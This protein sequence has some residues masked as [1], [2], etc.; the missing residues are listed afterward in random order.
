M[1]TGKKLTAK[2]D[3]QE[4]GADVDVPDRRDVNRREFLH[5][6]LLGAAGIPIAACAAGTTIPDRA[7][8]IST[9]DS[10]A[11]IPLDSPENWTE[12]WIWRPSDWPGQQLHL[13][14]V[15][16]EN[17]GAIV[18]FGNPSA[19]L[20]SYNGATPGPTIRME[21]NET[22]FVRLR[23]LLDEDIGTTFV[24]PFLDPAGGAI[25]DYFDADAAQKKASDQGQKRS[26]YC[27]GEHTNGVHSIHVTN[28]HT[29]GLHVRPGRNPDGTHSD[30]VILRLINQADFRRREQQSAVS[31][32]A[33]LGDPEQTT[34]LQ[35][36]EQPGFADYEFRIG[37]VQA[38]QIEKAGLPPQPH[39]PGTHWYHPHSH[40]AT[41]N[42]VA[43]GM[44]GFLIVEGDV[45]EA[46]NRALTDK[47][48]PNPQL[49][50]GTYDYMERLMFMQRVFTGNIAR[51]QDGPTQTLKQGGSANL[52][53][54][55]DQTPMIIKMR[56]GAIERWRILNGS[57]DGR[58][59]KRFMVLKGQYDVDESGGDELVHLVDPKSGR[60]EPVTRAQVEAD[61]QQLY[62]L[63]FDGVTLVEGGPDGAR[64][65]IKNLATQNHGTTNPL[66]GQ[67]DRRYP[68]RTM[69]ANFENCFRDATTINNCFVRPNEV[70]LGPANRTDVFFQA[71]RE[72]GRYTVLARAVVVHADNYQNTLMTPE[73]YNSKD[74]A[75][76][77]QDIVVAYII[78]EEGKDAQGHNLPP[79]PEYDV[80]KLIDVLPDVPPYLQ[81]IGDDEVRVK[82]GDSDLSE[83]RGKYRTRTITYSG[84]GSADFPLVTTVEGDSK[85]SQNPVTAQNF[86]KFV[87]ADQAHDALLRDL[88]YTQIKVEDGKD[89]D[90]KIRWKPVEPEE[91]VLLPANIRSMAIT[92]STSDELTREGVPKSRGRKFDPTDVE[93]PMML[94]GTAE[95]W[96]L[97]NYSISLWADTA[98]DNQ[99]V[100]Q[101]KGH[102]AA[103]P[104]TRAKGQANFKQQSNDKKSWQLVTKS[105]DHPFHIHQN[106]CWVTRIEIPDEKGNLVNILD[107]PRWQ[108]VM[109]I[110]RN[111]GRVIFRSRFPDYVGAYVNHCHILLHEDNGMMQVIEVTP[112]ANQANYEA[113]DQLAGSSASSE[114][115]SAI[116]PR[117]T[118]DEAWLQSMQFIDPNDRTGQEYPGFE[119]APPLQRE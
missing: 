21:G 74:L 90:G 27:L 87:E 45:D 114:D 102:Y 38:K 55:G 39:P 68:N 96:A 92:G 107:A 22:L 76:G 105:V 46:I 83:Q 73:T 112:F 101:Y 24:G 5:T 41:H 115:V 19:V 98:A 84:W 31:E 43:S 47:P 95:E 116:Y 4:G 66:D 61:K 1:I 113:K 52:A 60:F 35:D 8:R 106:P 80:M 33:F 78:V 93:R 44:A 49:K 9:T 26:D 7:K 72:P 15:E 14:V 97:Y 119:I 108:D 64:Y 6:A 71:P 34:F 91:Y 20:F 117:K 53:V 67:L 3:N 12:P 118:L 62:Q 17:P 54:N 29:H 70:Y 37:N 88:R 50:T 111:G 28:L 36:D 89:A 109:W 58:G 82:E 42:Q 81:P 57:V 18:G 65:V 48:N 13:N 32:C 104:L 103:L 59:F 86:G 51:D 40:G 16:N 99:P 23:N 69:L 63:A 110:P 100:G 56:P 79:I 94:S 10:P 85:S 77:P 25:P 11:T 30:N 2:H 75:T